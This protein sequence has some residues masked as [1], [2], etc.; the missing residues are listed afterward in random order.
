MHVRLTHC[1]FFTGVGAFFVEVV[2]IGYVLQNTV[3]SQMV[4]TGLEW[5]DE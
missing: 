1:A 4:D 5:T 3:R 2:T